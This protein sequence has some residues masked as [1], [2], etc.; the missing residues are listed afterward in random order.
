MPGDIRVERGVAVFGASADSTSINFGTAAAAADKAFVRIT[1]VAYC[2]AGP[3]TATAATRNNDDLGCYID[4]TT[5]TENGFDLVRD[6]AGVN[7][8]VRVHWELWDYVG[9][10]GGSWEFS[11]PKRANVRA[12][13]GTLSG[14]QGISAL[15]PSSYDNL[16]PVC[17]GVSS[18][19]TGRNWPDASIALR[20]DKTASSEA[21]DW[22][23]G[24]AAATTNFSYCL[25]D[26]SGS[27][28]TVENNITHQ[29]T[30]AG[31]NETETI[32]DVGSWDKAFI[33]HTFRTVNT[34]LDESTCNVWPGS[35]TTSMR[36][37]MRSSA[38]SAV[39]YVVE[40]CTVSASKGLSVEHLDSITGTGTDHGSGSN[41]TSV[42]IS[43][44]DAEGA[45]AIAS[46]DCAGSGTA[47]GRFA[48][49]YRINNSTNAEFWRSYNGQTGDWAMQIVAF[50]GQTA[51]GDS[52]F[53]VTDVS[54]SNASVVRS[55]SADTTFP[56]TDVLTGNAGVIR[57]G[58][59]DITFAK[60]DMES[61][62]TP[63]PPPTYTIPAEGDCHI[64]VDGSDSSYKFYN[65]CPGTNT[66]LG[67]VNPTGALNSEYTL[68]ARA[69]NQ[70]VASKT[71]VSNVAA[72][73][74]DAAY[75]NGP[76]I[77]GVKGNGGSLRLSFQ[78][79]TSSPAVRESGNSNVAWDCVRNNTP[80]SD[81]PA[82]YN[83]AF[84]GFDI[85]IVGLDSDAQMRWVKQGPQHG[86]HS[87]VSA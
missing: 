55:G 69:L 73:L 52:T 35:T 68:I 62:R 33:F 4:Q 23:R 80:F 50:I 17:T 8:D 26:W 28:W 2:S 54:A 7:E 83:V 65:G 46:S 78:D 1:N 72:A 85:I 74:T 13:S 82:G 37:R 21:V 25:V 81:A 42:T 84:W 12:S 64:V 3:D 58:S 39:G 44:V 51:Q 86:N 24:N 6:A 15:N 61:P 77:I 67:G 40:A 36:F 29:F 70:A 32:T 19:N 53:P 49:G 59:G 30:A 5:V 16:T 14:S 48:W 47:Y 75:C 10:D 87:T 41:T 31:V 76:V 45:G 18:T 63:P 57:S 71:Y 20:L 22:Q 79:T 60:T 27:A 56:V 43:S 66:T 9:P 34:G 38:T 11:V